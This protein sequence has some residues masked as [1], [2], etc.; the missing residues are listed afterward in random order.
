MEAKVENKRVKQLGIFLL[1]FTI[2][3]LPI[4]WPPASYVLTKDRAYSWNDQ[5]RIA[6][7]EALVERHTFK[8]EESRY[9]LFTGDKIMNG[10][11]FYATKPPVLS[12]IGGLVY[13]P[14]YL[15]W[16]VF[17][18]GE[19]L[20]YWDREEI[21]YPFVTLFT[22]GISS[23]LMLVF[24]FK[25]LLLF[26]MR[27][28][29][30]WWIVFAVGFGSLIFTYTTVFNNH[31]F[32]A[33][34]LFI[35]FYF[36][37]RAHLGAAREYQSEGSKPVR[38]R[39]LDGFIGGMCIALAGVCDLSGALA[40]LPLGFLLML[41]SRKTL[42]LLP[43]YILGA[44]V[45]LLPH[46]ALNWKI[47]GDP[48]TPVYLMRSKYLT[49]MPGYFGE[50]FDQGE[51]H[52]YSQERWVYIFHSLFGQR[53]AFLY[54][55]VLLFGF[56][57][58]YVAIRRN[59]YGL[60]LAAITALLGIGAGWIY[61]CF[62]PANWGGTSYGLRYAVTSTPLI[63]FFAAALF[64]GVSKISW[65]TALFRETAIIGGVLALIG[66]VYPWG[67]AGFLPTTNFSLAENMQYIGL[68]ILDMLLK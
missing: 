57:G 6:T 3:A 23:A 35:G 24:L 22:I 45:F 32:S 17:H 54:T 61:M 15:I 38:P 11:S 62:W 63:I 10:S 52:W 5:A 33:A 7:V 47:T 65:K 49:T 8:I 14:L 43:M 18:D 39:M 48:F 12:F 41:M 59:T 25:A 58:L 40:F 46:F 19:K 50:V 44:L 27:E 42:R 4:M 29:F 68:D 16:P 2:F 26:D 60:R 64:D 37:L 51:V 9:G 36:I 66:A 67:A 20:S 53:G 31:S 34:W 21:I 1:Y 28:R 56:A 30:R 55:P 13:E